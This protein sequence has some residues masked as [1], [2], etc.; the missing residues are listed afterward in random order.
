MLKLDFYI[1]CG[2]SN[3][4]LIPASSVDS[5]RSAKAE[6]LKEKSVFSKLPDIQDFRQTQILPKQA[7][8][9]VT[10]KGRQGEPPV[11]SESGTEH[12]GYALAPPQRPPGLL[13]TCEEVSWVWFP[14]T[15]MPIKEMAVLLEHSVMQLRI[16]WLLCSW[17]FASNLR[18]L[19]GSG[20]PICYLISF[21]KQLEPDYAVHH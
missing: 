12:L 1:Y 10:R 13:S 8:S 6:N 18:S 17:P 19:N 11:I 5:P 9:H 15:Q 20:D 4:F 16:F 3:S 2:L 7:C 14:A 21:H